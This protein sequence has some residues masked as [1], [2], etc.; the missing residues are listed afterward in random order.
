[1]YNGYLEEYKTKFK[2]A[3]M[4]DISN[5][6]SK[7]DT[8]NTAYEEQKRLQTSNK[9]KSVAFSIFGAVTDEQRRK[10]ESKFLEKSSKRVEEVNTGQKSNAVRRLRQ[11]TQKVDDRL[12]LSQSTPANSNNYSDEE[13]RLSKTMPARLK[14]LISPPSSPTQTALKTPI[15]E[16][17]LTKY[18]VLGAIRQDSENGKQ[19][20]SSKGNNSEPQPLPAIE[21]KHSSKGDL[22]L[23]D[24]N[25]E[26]QPLPAIE[27]KHSSK[28]DLRFNR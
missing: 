19:P 2:N 17:P 18:P 13:Q 22:R 5:V 6:K 28:G 24:N 21:T 23:T 9:P 26:P 20:T 14:P 8:R 7:I 12:K 11:L 16:K 27:T 3:D 1:M 10:M 25:S 15:E 4:P